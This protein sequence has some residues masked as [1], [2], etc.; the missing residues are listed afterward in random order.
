MRHRIA[1]F[2]ALDALD[3]LDAVKVAL[4]WLLASVAILGCSAREKSLEQYVIMLKNEDIA[5]AMRSGVIFVDRVPDSVRR[6]LDLQENEFNKCAS[7]CLRSDSNKAKFWAIFMLSKKD[8][9]AV[10]L[11]DCARNKKWLK[12][13]AKQEGGVAVRLLLLQALKDAP[14]FDGVQ[15]AIFDSL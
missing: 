8:H 6:V 13:G 12:D 10:Q 14:D 1:R 9:V 7:E 15:G 11:M 5:Y 4:T 2:D 3:T